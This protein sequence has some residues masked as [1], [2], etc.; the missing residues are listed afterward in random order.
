MK[1]IIIALMIITASIFPKPALAADSYRFLAI[2]DSITYS[3]PIKDIWY[4]S[5]GASASRAENDW[6]HLVSA[7][8]KNHY[9]SVTSDVISINWERVPENLASDEEKVRQASATPYDL[10]VIENAD[11]VFTKKQVS[12]YQN[13]LEHF[14]HTIKEVNPNAQIV[15][16]NDFMRNNRFKGK[17]ITKPVDQILK[18]VAKNFS[19]SLCD[20][21]AV[22]NN[23]AYQAPIGTIVYGTDGQAHTVDTIGVALHPGDKGMAYIASKVLEKINITLKTDYR[24]DDAQAV[25]ELSGWQKIGNKTY[26]YRDHKKLTGLRYIGT[27]YYFFDSSGALKTKTFTAGSTTYYL[28]NKGALELIRKGSAYYNEN[29]LPLKKDDGT[30]QE[31]ILKARAKVAQLSKKTDTKARKLAKCQQWLKTRK[32]AGSIKGT[33][34]QNALALFE[35]KRTAESTACALAYMAYVIGYKN[36]ALAKQN[37]KYTVLLNNKAIGRRLTGRYKTVKIPY[38]S[39]KPLHKGKATAIVRYNTKERKLYYNNGDAVTGIAVY[40]NQF[41][42]FDHSGRYKAKQTNKL[43][44][45]AVYFGDIGKVRKILGKPKRTQYTAS[46]IAD[47]DD[48]IWQYRDFTITTF[49]NRNGSEV[50]VSAKS[51]FKNR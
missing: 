10:I 49:R 50:F 3:P 4:G 5:W 11:P 23:P 51:H 32:K 45:A 30:E 47:G 48:G 12:H 34:A 7:E 36:V 29:N 16:I 19:C 25:K 24:F 22:A 28:N 38:G 14:I 8:L 46:C 41:Y 27:H 44:K 21:S 31:V 33:A 40:L 39:D 15:L 9:A 35:N 43:R 17:D 26:Y 42:V 20:L 37:G 2:G 1:K 6:V 18:T 13:N